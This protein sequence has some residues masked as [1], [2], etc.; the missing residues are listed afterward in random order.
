M[1]NTVQS[2]EHRHGTAMLAGVCREKLPILTDRLLTAIFTDIPEWTDYTSVPL[3]ELRD[4]CGRY[5]ARILDLL[6]GTA[7]NPEHDEVAAS[8][9]EL[10]AT[11]G[12]PLEAMLR[13]FRLGGRIVW[14]SLLDGTEAVDVTPR[15]IRE[16]G[17]A[18][19]TV[20]DGLSSAL[21]TAYRNTELDR[22]RDDERRTHA[23][24]EDVLMG[25]AHD[26]VVALRCGRE[27][28]LPVHSGY[29]VIVAEPL[30][31]GRP[32]LSNPE[33]ALR[34]MGIRSVWH[35][36]SDT[37]VGIVAL[38]DRNADA[39]I[40]IL[41]PLTRGRATCSP[42]VTDLANVDSAH[43][44]ARIA[45]E[46]LTT[47]AAGLTLLEE[48]FP[49][50]LLVRSPD[51]AGGLVSR[52]LGP[53]LALPHSDRETLIQTLTE[54][55]RQDCSAAHAAPRLHCHRNTVLNRLQRISALVGRPLDG[56]RT[57]FEFS[58]ALA[59]LEV[60]GRTA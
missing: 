39:V 7:S 10:R 29:L 26:T 19:W 23:L 6:S 49:E 31:D 54:W 30:T 36:R 5:L 38:A 34:A 41:R 50:A 13:T 55:L 43:T 15:E 8:I 14:E 57:H 53:I 42:E 4:A 47:S 46:T 44:F 35:R 60:S 56:H 51:L 3:A 25:R 32:A 2:T 11:Q 48:R 24:I 22:V 17:T 33:A 45:M 37:S 1:E 12:V 27:L 52:M 9:G 40:S 59:A 20:I 18:M 16:S 21:S 28:D 58:L